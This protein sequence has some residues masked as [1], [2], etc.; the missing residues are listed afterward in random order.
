MLKNNVTWDNIFI[1]TVVTELN[2]VFTV[3][4]QLRYVQ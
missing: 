4:F 3:H 2:I 1:N